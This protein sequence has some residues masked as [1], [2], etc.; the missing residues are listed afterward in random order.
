MLLGK[1]HL[2]CTHLPTYPPTHPPT[3]VYFT[4][5]PEPQQS[6]SSKI[7]TGLANRLGSPIEGGGSSLAWPR[8]LNA[9]RDKSEWI[10]G[11]YK[12]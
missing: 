3:G 6:G 4:P 9:L 11:V 2:C 12:L 10:D 1:Q 8:L 7:S 5:T